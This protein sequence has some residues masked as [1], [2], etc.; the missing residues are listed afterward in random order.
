MEKWRNGEIEKG[1]E[2]KID[3]REKQLALLVG[4][5]LCSCSQDN[6]QQQVILQRPVPLQPSRSPSILRQWKILFFSYN[7]NNTNINNHPSRYS[8][9]TLDLHWFLF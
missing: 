9:T 6:K 5:R 1:R 7:N 4:V 8:S 2:T 3:G